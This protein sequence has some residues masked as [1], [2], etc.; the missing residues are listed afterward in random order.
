MRR[1]DRAIPIV[2]LSAAITGCLAQAQNPASSP[3][4]AMCAN[5]DSSHSERSFSI[6]AAD[7]RLVTWLAPHEIALATPTTLALRHDFFWKPHRIN[8]WPATLT[9]EMAE[10]FENQWYAKLS[11]SSNLN[12]AAT[13]VREFRNWPVDLLHLDVLRT[14]F[15]QNARKYPGLC[16]TPSKAVYVVA[17]GV[18]V[19]LPSTSYWGRGPFYRKPSDFELFGEEFTYVFLL[20]PND[21]PAG[22]E[23]RTSPV[24]F[25]SIG[26]TVLGS[27]EKPTFHM[28]QPCVAAMLK[29]LASTK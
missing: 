22:S 19:R 12:W 16:L 9:P 14:W 17:V 24:Y 26:P 15:T 8:T 29:Y 1:L 23:R 13:D 2:F 7:Y 20:R 25:F 10:L 5:S 3:V 11:A 27:N 21:T 6:A 28:L 18:A 4:D